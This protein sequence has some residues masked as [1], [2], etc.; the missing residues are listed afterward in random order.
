MAKICH[1]TAQSTVTEHC[2]ANVYEGESN[3]NRP[4]STVTS[5]RKRS[6]RGLVGWWGEEWGPLLL[7]PLPLPFFRSLARTMSEKEVPVTVV[8]R[9]IMKF[10]MKENVGVPKF[11]QDCTHSMGNWHSQRLQVKVWHKKFRRTRSRR[12]R[13]SPA[14]PTNGHKFFERCSGSET[15]WRWSLFDRY[16]DFTGTSDQ[17]WKH[18]IHHKKMNCN[19]EKLLPDRYHSCWAMNRK[20]FVFKF[21]KHSWHA[22]RMKVTHFCIT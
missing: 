3:L 19:I 17:L 6:K 7:C 11:G 22:T 18:A 21:V 14:A 9:I 5:E 2:G 15:Y 12:K 16:S 4:Q 13:Q 8:Q 1:S 10:L 20:M